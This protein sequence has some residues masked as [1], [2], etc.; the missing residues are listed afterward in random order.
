MLISKKEQLQNKIE[1]QK[2]VIDGKFSTSL[3]LYVAGG[4][5]FRLGGTSGINDKLVFLL[6]VIGTVYLVMTI[7]EKIT[8]KNYEDE[9]VALTEYHTLIYKKGNEKN[10]PP[11]NKRIKRTKVVAMPKQKRESGSKV[12]EFPGNK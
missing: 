9:L 5:L 10:D 12:I 4:L 11:L 1:S 8:K 2:A 7:R 6:G 3:M